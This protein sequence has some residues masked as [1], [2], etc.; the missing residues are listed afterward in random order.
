MWALEN[1][2]LMEVGE[3][4]HLLAPDVRASRFP[5]PIKLGDFRIRIKIE[6]D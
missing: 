3:R 2:M 1:F 4:D 6:L 5:S